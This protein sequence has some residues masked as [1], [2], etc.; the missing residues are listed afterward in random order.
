MFYSLFGLFWDGNGRISRLLS[1]LLLYRN[2]LDAGKYVSFEEQ[3]NKHKASY[4]EA[5]RL[6]SIG[7][8]EGKNDYMPFVKD[9]IV[10]LYLCY[11]E[12]DDRF[13]VVQG[14]KFSKEHRIEATLLNSLL[15]MTKRDLLTLLPDVSETTVERVLGSLL[16]EGK[17]Q[18]LGGNRNASYVKA[19]RES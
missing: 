7:W 13:A 5:L 2:G 6:S 14:K 12:L 1:L 10:T 4:Y 15:P 16:K 17:I 19:E 8:Q 18:K 11:K 3:I 9:F